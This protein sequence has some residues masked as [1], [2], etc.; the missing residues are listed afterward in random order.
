MLPKTLVALAVLGLAGVAHAGPLDTK[1]EE[2]LAID[3][4][5]VGGPAYYLKCS[6]K[7]LA[8]CGFVTVYAQANEL[9]GLQT[10]PFNTGGRAIPPDAKVLG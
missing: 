2:N 5:A 9:D 7:T 4:T 10:A 1:G 6:G 3:L 8:N